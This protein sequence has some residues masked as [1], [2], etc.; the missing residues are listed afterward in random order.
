L[1]WEIKPF[2]WVEMVGNWNATSPLLRCLSRLDYDAFVTGNIPHSIEDTT[3]SRVSAWI[4]NLARC[5]VQHND[6][7]NVRDQIVH[8]FVDGTSSTCPGRWIKAFSINMKNRGIVSRRL[9]TQHVSD[10]ILE[11]FTYRALTYLVLQ[12]PVP[13][14]PRDFEHLVLIGYVPSDVQKSI[15]HC[16]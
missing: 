4:L 1:L 16:N 5:A 13:F 15:Y 2:S 9:V 10:E 11:I 6:L 12:E 8:L 14:D 3:W 7:R